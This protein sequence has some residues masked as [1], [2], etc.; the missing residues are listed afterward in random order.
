MICILPDFKTKTRS[1]CKY[2]LCDTWACSTGTFSCDCWLYWYFFYST[3]NS[4]FFRWQSVDEQKK[5]ALTLAL[6]P[7]PFRCQQKRP[8]EYAQCACLFVWVLRPF[9]SIAVIVRRPAILEWRKTPE[10]HLRCTD[11]K[12]GRTTDLPQAS[13]KASSH[14]KF[15][16]LARLEPT[17]ARDQ[18]V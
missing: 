10:T 7:P 2:D 5:S 12:L 1:L 4:T 14:R 11:S 6:T 13:R 9:D 17:A 3:G 18:G 8:V 15:S 16:P